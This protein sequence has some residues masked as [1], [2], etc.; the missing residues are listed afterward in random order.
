M[1]QP[2]PPSLVDLLPADCGAAAELLNRG[3]VCVSVDHPSL[4]RALED[5]AGRVSHAE[6]LA[7]RSHLFS[8]SMVFVSQAHLLRM[9]QVVSV[10]ERVVALLAIAF[11]AVFLYFV[12]RSFY[13]MRIVQK[14]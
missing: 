9:A 14:K 13:G 6:L 12:Y 5:T 1:N 10:V 3:C 7:T 8:D 11:L 2:L 4:K